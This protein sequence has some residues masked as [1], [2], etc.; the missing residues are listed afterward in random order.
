MSSLTEKKGSLRQ[1]KKKAKKDAEKFKGMNTIRR[2]R[3]TALS[4][5]IEKYFQDPENEIYKSFDSKIRA[6][7]NSFLSD[8]KN[9]NAFTEFLDTNMPKRRDKRPATQQD[10][11]DYG[12][13]SPD[14]VNETIQ[15]LTRALKPFIKQQLRGK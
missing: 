14:R 3:R 13:G 4:K 8:D 15:K 6:A 12:P 10:V 1:R 11:I 7:I 2:T 5:V 9:F